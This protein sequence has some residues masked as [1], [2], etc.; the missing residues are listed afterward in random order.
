MVKVKVTLIDCIMENMLSYTDVMQN[1]VIYQFYTTINKFCSIKG[2]L[3]L[4]EQK[5]GEEKH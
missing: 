5:E 4:W 1:Q 2:M 3:K